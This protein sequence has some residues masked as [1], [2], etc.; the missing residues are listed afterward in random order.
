MSIYD[1][2]AYGPR[3]HKLTASKAELDELVERSLRRAA[4][5]E[6]AKDRLDKPASASPAASSSACASRAPS[7]SRPP[8]S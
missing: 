5:W 6:E 4:L 2:V 7:P 1:N 8:S 3:T